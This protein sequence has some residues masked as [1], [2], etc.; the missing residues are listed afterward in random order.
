MQRS[1]PRTSGGSYEGQYMRLVENNEIKLSGSAVLGQHIKILSSFSPSPTDTSLTD[2]QQTL[3][4]N[5]TG[6]VLASSTATTFLGPA[7]SSPSLQ[8]LLQ[9]AVFECEHTVWADDI[10]ARQHLS[11]VS[12]L[13]MIKHN[14][15]FHPPV[16]CNMRNTPCATLC[17]TL[18]HSATHVYP[19][20]DAAQQVVALALSHTLSR[21]LSHA[22]ACSRFLLHALFLS[23]IHSCF[24]SRMHSC[25]L[26]RSFGV[27]LSVSWCVYLV[28]VFRASMSP[29]S[30][31]FV[32]LCRLGLSLSCVYVVLVCLFRVSI[33]SGS[34]SF[35]CTHALFAFP[36]HALSRPVQLSF[37]LA[38]LRTRFLSRAARFTR[39]PP[40]SPPFPVVPFLSPS[41]TLSRIPSLTLSRIPCRAYACAFTL[42]LSL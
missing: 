2:W 19:P 31:S 7:S 3:A 1:L 21:T 34:V 11:D 4:C 32:C 18:Q 25:F 13:R 23:R 26:S 17:N 10:D 40:P 15:F 9:S 35:V 16:H 24:L 30:V 27:S 36:S 28:L 37:S 14:R 29:W 38:L 5:N 22:S 33:W 20:N 8:S 12:I 6:Q 39:L 41:L 42:R